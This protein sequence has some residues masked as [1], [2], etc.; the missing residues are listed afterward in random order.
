[1]ATIKTP[2]FTTPK[3]V[4]KY[5]WLNTPDTKFNPDGDYKITVVLGAEAAAPIVKFLDERLEASVAQAKKDN[6]GKKVREAD[7]PYKV[8]EETGEVEVTFK[9]KAKVNMKNGDSFEQKPTIFDA[10]LRPLKDINVGGGSVVK[11]NYECFGFYTALIGAGVSLRLKA[12]QVLNLVEFSG[13]LSAQAMGF[14]EEEG[15]EQEVEDTP[16]SNSEK[17]DEENPEDF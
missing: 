9:M 16:F 17:S 13:G 15:F 14:K 2:N 12:V 4:A 1:M 7:P 8:N 6:V 3:G 11:V 10:K 5:P